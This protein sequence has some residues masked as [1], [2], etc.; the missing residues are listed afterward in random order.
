MRRLV[1][2]EKYRKARKRKFQRSFLLVNHSAVLVARVDPIPR[3][4]KWVAT[5][6]LSF[7][8][9]HNGPDITFHDS[10]GDAKNY[11]VACIRLEDAA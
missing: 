6:Y 1:W 3:S 7:N 9:D 10:A 11:L 2:K 4:G 5:K 8:S